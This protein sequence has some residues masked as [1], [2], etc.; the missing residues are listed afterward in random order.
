MQAKGSI[1]NRPGFAYDRVT[2]KYVLS[3]EEPVAKGS[4]CFFSGEDLNK[5]K[6]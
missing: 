6:E 2:K 3:E 4:F 1:D 5:F